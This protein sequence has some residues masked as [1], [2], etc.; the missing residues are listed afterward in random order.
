MNEK[1]T[2]MTR[3]ES[4][5][6]QQWEQDTFEEG[7]WLVQCS[8]ETL[9]VV[10]VQLPAIFLLIRITN[11]LSHR[12]EKD[13]LKEDAR[14][15]WFHIG[16][17]NARCCV[18]CLWRPHLGSR[19]RENAGPSGQRG[20]NLEGLGKRPGSVVLQQEADSV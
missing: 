6:V 19:Q 2:V 11:V 17:K 12:I 7:S 18:T 1:G 16:N 10:H 9:I 15:R 5:Y 14:L 3:A 4:T 8:F 13:T 20:D